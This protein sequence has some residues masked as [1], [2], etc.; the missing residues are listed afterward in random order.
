MMDPDTQD[1]E[2]HEWQDPIQ[3]IIFIFVLVVVLPNVT[4]LGHLSR[5]KVGIITVYTYFTIRSVQ[6]ILA[7][8]G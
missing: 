3:V 6:K 2:D 5:F 7:Y 4:L 8:C 1:G